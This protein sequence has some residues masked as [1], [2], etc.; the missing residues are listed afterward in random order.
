MKKEILTWDEINE[1]IADDEMKVY[2]V[3]ELKN[4]FQKHFFFDDKLTREFISRIVIYCDEKATDELLLNFQ[5]LADIDAYNDETLKNE[6]TQALALRYQ[7]CRDLSKLNNAKGEEKRQKLAEILA[8]IDT[9]DRK[10]FAK[11]MVGKMIDL[12]LSSKKAD[13]KAS[14]D[15]YPLLKNAKVL[16][17]DPIKWVIKDHYRFAD[18][19]GFI[20]SMFAL[21]QRKYIDSRKKTTFK[22][23]DIGE[24]SEIFTS[25]SVVCKLRGERVQEILDV[26][27]DFT[28]DT[29]TRS[30]IIEPKDIVK[31]V[32]TILLSNVSELKN[33]IDCLKTRF[34]TDKKSERKLLDRVALS[35]SIL[36]CDIDKINHFENVL[37]VTIDGTIARYY[38]QMEE[39]Y[40]KKVAHKM[41][42]DLDKFNAIDRL[43]EKDIEGLPKVAEVLVKHFGP[44]N[45]IVCLEDINFLKINDRLLDYL[46][47]KLELEERNGKTNLREYLFQN[48]GSVLNMLQEDSIPSSSDKPKHTGE[49]R[50]V[51]PQEEKS[52]N[53]EA[54]PNETTEEDVAKAYARL[55]DEQKKLAEGIVDKVLEDS[56]IEEEE[57]Q[58]EEK[59]PEEWDF[60]VDKLKVIAHIQ[61]ITD[62]QIDTI[63]K[64]FEHKSYSDPFM[65]ILD[66]FK[67]L[68]DCQFS[69]NVC[70]KSLFMDEVKKQYSAFVKY[71]DNLDLQ[72][73]GEFVDL[74]LSL[75]KSF[76]HLFQTTYM[77]WNEDMLTEALNQTRRLNNIAS[78]V[79]KNINENLSGIKN[80]RYPDYL[81]K[82]HEGL[83][84]G[85]DID[86]FIMVEYLA[87]EY[88]KYLEKYVKDNYPERAWRVFPEGLI[89]KFLDKEMCLT[90]CLIITSGLKNVTDELVRLNAT[91]GDLNA[92]MT[93]KQSKLAVF[94][95]QRPSYRI[96]SDREAKEQK[97]MARCGEIG[98]N[99]FDTYMMIF[100][101]CFRGKQ[102]LSNW[103]S[104]YLSYDE[105]GIY[106]LTQ[107]GTYTFFP[108]KVEEKL[109][110]M[111]H[112]PKVTEDVKSKVSIT[113][114]RRSHY[115]KMEYVKDEKEEEA[116]TEEQAKNVKEEEKT[117]KKNSSKTKVD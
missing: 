101:G 59:H 51:K 73:A 57:K 96:F 28:Y 72:L 116:S 62:E 25:A 91:V 55:N 92:R 86:R 65:E 50:E 9:L 114:S 82:D 107:S 21:T 104:F 97:I 34:V 60:E 4:I 66:R 22:L 94:S 54:L 40:G 93:Q 44:K 32:K 39:D 81:E 110:K 56:T 19:D 15:F 63:C 43:T 115:E 10:R 42:F 6:R 80:I 112:I 13:H 89:D 78:K 2:S 47:G 8:E 5:H 14:K 113:L 64:E 76:E 31:K 58:D 41:C 16:G 23:F 26:L 95:P 111:Y 17:I 103:T 67:A 3:E 98:S 74:N 84:K 71:R 109:M 108:C 20:D 70:E 100:E 52:L 87:L 106:S 38:L 1:L 105:N 77:G 12:S 61:T 68:V 69:G 24:I 48:S 88:V 117:E 79:R 37:A 36:V 30:Y 53:I 27:G 11:T 102:D 35:P 83:D 99:L 90:K 75:M 18:L 85:K 46:L 29:D 45:A 49:K 7:K 33:M